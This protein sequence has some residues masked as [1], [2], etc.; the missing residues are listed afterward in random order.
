MSGR[1]SVRVSIY[2]SLAEFHLGIEKNAGALL[3]VP[4]AVT[5]LLVAPAALVEL[6]PIVALAVGIAAEVPWLAAY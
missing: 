3:G 4:F 6:S 1:D 2:D 5:L